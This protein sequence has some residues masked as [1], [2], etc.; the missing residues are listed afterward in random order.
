MLLQVRE[1]EVLEEGTHNTFRYRRAVKTWNEAKITNT[2]LLYTEKH[3]W[4]ESKMTLV[5]WAI[6]FAEMY[7]IQ[8]AMTSS[9]EGSLLSGAFDHHE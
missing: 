8:Q 1:R 2:R 9:S 5:I 7:V 3:R 6:V 4:S